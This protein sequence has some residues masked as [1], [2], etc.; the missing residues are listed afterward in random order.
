MYGH[1]LE[2]ERL[3]VF[4]PEEPEEG[5][6][7][8]LETFIP[9]TIYRKSV[10]ALIF[11]LSALPFLDGLILRTLHRLA[12]A[13]KLLGAATAICGIGPGAAASIVNMEGDLEGLPVAADKE[14]AEELIED[15]KKRRR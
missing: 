5:Y 10:R 9:E 11:D 8:Y 2:G 12:R 14:Q 7:A 13:A 15:L 6:L 1:V 4:L 3:Y